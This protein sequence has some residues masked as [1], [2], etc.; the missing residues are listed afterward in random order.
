MS[1]VITTTNR[2]IEKI[3]VHNEHLIKL[4]SKIYHCFTVGAQVEEFHIQ[5]NELSSYIFYQFYIEVQ[6]M[7][8][9]MFP[10]VSSHTEEHEGFINEITEMR[11]KL[12][13][14]DGRSS[15]DALLILIQRF[16][17]HILTSDQK[18]RRFV[19]DNPTVAIMLSE[20]ALISSLKKLERLIVSDDEVTERFKSILMSETNEHVSPKL[21]EA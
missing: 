1:E 5:I 3:D 2:L 12:A 13:R 21:P 16:T 14:S 9:T 8:G 18:Y 6:W 15:L 7:S 4:L 17:Q 20:N 10:D 19:S 11:L